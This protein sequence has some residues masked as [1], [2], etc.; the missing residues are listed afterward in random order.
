MKTKNVEIRMIELCV[1][2][3]WEMPDFKP[4]VLC[5][6]YDPLVPGKLAMCLAHNTPVQFFNT[7]DLFEKRF[8]S[9]IPF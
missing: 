5:E 3:P 9:D 8:S 1:G 4:C 6:D 2:K 7:C